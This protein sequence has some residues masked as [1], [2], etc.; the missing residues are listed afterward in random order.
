MGS[1]MTS[2]DGPSTKN[3]LI[4]GVGNRLMG[5]DGFGPRVIDLLSSAPLPENV[6]VRDVGTAGLA[7]A[8]DLSDYDL[9]VFIDSVN[10]EGETGRLYKWDIVEGSM[11]DV[12]EL[13]RFTLHEVGLDGLLK[14]SKAMG[15]LPPRVILIGCKPESLKPGLELSPEVEEVLHKAAEMALDAV[16]AFRSGCGE[17]L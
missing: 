1:G 8:T 16:S 15:T 10:V 14:L 17:S 7:I 6:E 4:A 11:G 9:V 5:D 12:A 13:S 2:A 3:V